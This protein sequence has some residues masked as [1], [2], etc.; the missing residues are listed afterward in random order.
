[1]HN[2]FGAPPE[3]YRP[4]EGVVRGALQPVEPSAGF[5]EN[6]RGN[7]HIAVERQAS[8]LVI[9]RGQTFRAGVVIGISAGVATALIAALFFLLRPHSLRSPN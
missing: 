5:R 4:I 2:P 8:G 9:E 1:M 3:A 6:L 7:L